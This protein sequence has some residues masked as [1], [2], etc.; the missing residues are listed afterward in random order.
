[1]DLKSKPQ[2]SY[3]CLTYCF[4]FTYISKRCIGRLYELSQSLPS[5]DCKGWKIL[6]RRK[7]IR[8]TQIKVISINCISPFLLVINLICWKRLNSWI[9][10]WLITEWCLE[11]S[12]TPHS[13][14]CEAI[15][16]V[17]EKTT[18]Q[19]A[20]FRDYWRGSD[21]VGETHSSFRRYYQWQVFLV[22]APY[23]CKKE[24]CEQTEPPEKES[25]LEQ[26][27]PIRLIL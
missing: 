23:R 17:D 3:S 11:N 13:T 8:K 6:F 24:F 18:H 25:V 19:S 12:L 10:G 27:H 21:R 16:A 15:Y 2:A 4:S 1:M 22:T 26:K 7:W 5:S 9:V 14:K 20:Q